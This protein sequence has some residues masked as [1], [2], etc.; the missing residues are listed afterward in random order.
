MLQIKALARLVLFGTGRVRF[1][2]NSFLKVIHLT[3]AFAG[4]LTG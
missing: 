4:K 1:W 3:A 2:S